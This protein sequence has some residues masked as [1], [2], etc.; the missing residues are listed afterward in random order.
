MV[1][2][3]VRKLALLVFCSHTV[4][5]YFKK[6]VQVGKELESTNHDPKVN[7]H[8]TVSTTPREEWKSLVAEKIEVCTNINTTV[9]GGVQLV[10]GGL[11]VGQVC[12]GFW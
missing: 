5:P 2:W 11:D 10:S 3:D 12:V 9:Q 7:V 4:G 8:V 6:A 1:G